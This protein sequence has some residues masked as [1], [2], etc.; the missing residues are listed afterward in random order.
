MIN[1][2]PYENLFYLYIAIIAIIPCIILCFFKKRI[3]PIN[4]IISMIMTLLVFGLHSIQLIEFSLFILYEL[5]IIFG[6]YYFRKK[7]DSEFIYFLTFTLSIIPI[8]I[9]RIM[10]LKDNISEFVGF[11]GISYMC[12]KIWQLLFDI[13]DGK[14]EKL[15]FFHVVELLFFF[16]SFSS[17]PIITHKELNDDYENGLSNY[18]QEYFVFGFKKILLGL[19]YKFAVAYFI[20]T[21]FLSKI[22]DSSTIINIIK[23][24]YGYTFYLFFDFAGY[25]NMAIGIGSLM[26]LK[27]PENFNKPFLACNMKEFWQRWHMSLS[28]WFNDN[29]YN[30]FV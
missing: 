9:V 16:P 26:G 29:V 17:G 1:Y 10:A 27:M 2:T 6:F 21:L 12:F 20:N 11:I 15:N 8:F 18:F 28:R 30:K 24:M 3:R 22:G 25:S 13:H 23:Y 14:I 7:S 5:I 19:F 4:L